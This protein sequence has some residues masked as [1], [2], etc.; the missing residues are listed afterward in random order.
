MFPFADERVTPEE[1]QRISEQAEK[2]LCFNFLLLPM[3]PDGADTF[4]D[5]EGNGVMTRYDDVDWKGLARTL[6]AR[7]EGDV[8]KSIKVYVANDGPDIFDMVNTR[9]DQPDTP[10]TESDFGSRTVEVL[11]QVSM[12]DYRAGLLKLP[13]ESSLHLNPPTRSQRPPIA[14]LVVSVKFTKMLQAMDYMSSVMEQLVGQLLPLPVEPMSMMH[15]MDEPG[16]LP[17]EAHAWL[18]AQFGAVYSD[19]C[20]VLFLSTTHS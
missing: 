11:R 12:A 7:L 6:Q 8:P 3:V 9:L 16:T 17:P 5:R 15:A 13:E 19:K 18:E 2:P 10:E 14:G 4:L 1:W 20:G